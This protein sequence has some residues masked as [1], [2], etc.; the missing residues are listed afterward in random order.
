VETPKKEYIKSILA[1][2]WGII[3]YRKFVVAVDKGDRLR[4][5]MMKMRYNDVILF[6]DL[7]KK[8]MIEQQQ[9]SERQQATLQEFGNILYGSGDTDPDEL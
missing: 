3:R 5:D 9:D 8:D 2:I 1:A 7:L 6:C 4:M